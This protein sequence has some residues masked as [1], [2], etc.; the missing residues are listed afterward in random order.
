VSEYRATTLSSR[1][2]N[3]RL[4]PSVLPSRFSVNYRYS[5]AVSELASDY[6]GCSSLIVSVTSPADR[7]ES[8]PSGTVALDHELSGTFA[9]GGECIGEFARECGKLR[10]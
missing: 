3:N 6:S 9:R 1:N 7:E 10:L 8:F 2:F 5:E 4:P